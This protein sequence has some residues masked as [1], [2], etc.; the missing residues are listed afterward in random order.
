MP[1]DLSEWENLDD[2]FKRRTRRTV[3]RPLAARCFIILTTTPARLSSAILAGGTGWREALFILINIWLIG[4]DVTLLLTRWRRIE[5]V[6]AVAIIL[7]YSITHSGLVEL[8]IST[9]ASS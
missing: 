6:A 2:Y 1:R 3:G 4:E 7:F 9:S 5:I 8:G